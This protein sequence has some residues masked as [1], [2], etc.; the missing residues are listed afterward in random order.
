MNEADLVRT[1]WRELLAFA[2]IIAVV[3]L[4]TGLLCRRIWR[5]HR[6]S[7][8]ARVAPW[9]AWTLPALGIALPLSILL[10]ARLDH[11]AWPE[12]T[13]LEIVD[14]HPNYVLTPL[15]AYPVHYTAALLSV[16]FAFISP[17]F[18]APLAAT[19][20]RVQALRWREPAVFAASYATLWSIAL[21][22]PADLIA[23]FYD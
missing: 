21:F 17:L 15:E 6:T 12:P 3:A 20:A 13:H 9:F 11:G 8:V 2:G 1:P 19:C 16:F 22:A 18:F 23:L 10:R 7:R 4:P 5:D 14:G